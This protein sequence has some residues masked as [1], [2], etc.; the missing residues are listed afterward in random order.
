MKDPLPMAR[1]TDRHIGFI[2][3]AVLLT[4]LLLCFSTGISAQSFTVVIDAGHGGHDPGAV[5]R[6]S[7][8]KDI[9]LSVALKVGRL[10]EKECKD[11][12]VIYTR[13]TDV[14]VKLDRRAQIAN[15]AKADLF[16]SIHTNSLAKN[17]TAQGA[18][19][20]TL[21]LA[22]SDDNLEVAKRENSVILYEDDYKT[23]YADF[24]PNSSESYIIFEFM[25]DRYMSQSVRLASLMQKQ[26]K[27]TGHRIDNGVHQAGF[28]VLKAS[29][30]PSIL[31]EL[32]FISTPAEERY[33][34]T[35]KGQDTLADCIF[36][37]FQEYHNGQVGRSDAANGN[38]KQPA[39]Q[40]EST[41]QPAERKSETTEK[42]AQPAERKTETTERKA[43]SSDKKTQSE[44]RKTET[45]ASNAPADKPVFK[46][47]F[48][49]SSRQL[50]DN[51][52]RLK[53]LGT[54]EHYVENGIYKY[55]CGASTDYNQ[56]RR[57]YR[58]V[59]Q[60]YKDAFIIAFRGS[61]KINVNDA[62][63]EFKNNR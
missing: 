45:K 59:T 23:R 39:A 32:G 51:D 5:G 44:G 61:E 54:V 33:L 10:I 58:E 20:W 62:I 55:T 40:P 57:K 24:D 19:T 15:D 7:K 17:T 43:Q 46:I 47:Q 49:T 16:I 37:A 22:K 14:F 38:N 56:V 60:K 18:S 31:V 29:A 8:E 48:L 63:K 1:T 41:A 3:T 53:G 28:L 12:K 36:R 50:K 25:Q 6:T 11:V 42:K 13:K 21:G 27:N 4:V 26:F 2:G 34:N 35:A 52:S 30:M 9:N